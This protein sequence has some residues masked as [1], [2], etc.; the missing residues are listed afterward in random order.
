M[1][2][3]DINF[4]ASVLIFTNSTTFIV[5]NP[6]F[7]FNFAPVPPTCKRYVLHS[8]T[9]HNSPGCGCRSHIGKLVEHFIEVGGVLFSPPRHSTSAKL[10]YLHYCISVFS[11]STQ[12]LMRF[13]HKK[14]ET[15]F[16]SLFLISPI[17]GT[18]SNQM[19]VPVIIV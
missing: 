5:Q 6:I 15:F 7:M 10:T 12:F 8:Q 16:R 18:R 1:P 4:N 3:R 17:K 13:M 19:P 2:F 9:G 14:R 11:H